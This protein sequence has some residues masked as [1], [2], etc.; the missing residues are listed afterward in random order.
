MVTLDDAQRMMKA[1]LALKYSLRLMQ[2]KRTEASDSKEN[3]S[4]PP[5]PQRVVS[6]SDTESVV[7]VT[8]DE[9]AIWASRPLHALLVEAAES[10]DDEQIR[11]FVRELK[12]HQF[13]TT[14]R[15][16]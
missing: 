14:E 7:S 11:F 10:C 9:S 4:D 1:S 3:D 6:S 15:R 13:D 2:K 5:V 12:K 8:G 16:T